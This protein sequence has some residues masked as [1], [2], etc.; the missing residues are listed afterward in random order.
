MEKSVKKKI[1]TAGRTRVS[2]NHPL[3]GTWE[4]PDKKMQILVRYNHPLVGAWQEVENQVSESSVVYTIAVVK[5]RFAVSGIDESDGTKF[6]ISNVRWDGAA[7]QFSSLFPPTGHRVEHVFRALRPR[8]V[9]H[10][11]TYTGF[12]L[13]RKRPQKR[14]QRA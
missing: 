14:R 12:E 3:V 8:L 13:W 7:L 11:L 1:A 6:K 2:P 4:D 5:G 10:E 9:N